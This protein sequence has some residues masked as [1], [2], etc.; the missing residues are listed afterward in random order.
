MAE[1]EMMVSFFFGLI[2]QISKGLVLLV[3]ER[4]EKVER[5]FGSR[6]ERRVQSNEPVRPGFSSI[7]INSS[8]KYCAFNHIPCE[9]NRLSFRMTVKE[10]YKLNFKY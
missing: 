8:C 1:N 7:L 6:N 4:A 5:S 2:Y 9:K 10:I 3:V